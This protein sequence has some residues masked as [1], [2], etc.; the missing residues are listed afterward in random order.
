MHA[1]LPCF[2]T[3]DPQ[4]AEVLRAKTGAQRLQ[5]VDA[6]YR[7]A[8]SLIESNIRTR[9][10]DWNDATVLKMIARRIAGGTD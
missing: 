7:S 5:I 10:P 3:I 4:M 2:E 8:R 9:Y 6:L 1:T